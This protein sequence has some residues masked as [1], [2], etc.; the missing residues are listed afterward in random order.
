M[1]DVWANHIQRLKDGASQARTLEAV[2]EW[3]ERNTMMNGKPFSFSG[4]RYQLEILRDPSPN[5][6]VTKCSQIGASE[7]VARMVLAR[8]AIVQPYNV[9]Y[10]MPSAKASQ[11]FCK[12]RVSSVISESPYL[13]E[14]VDKN[15]D[16]VT[17]KKI[18]YSFIHFK[19][20][21]K[22]AQAISVNA[23]V[24]IADEYSYCD[25]TIVKQFNSR[26]TH[27]K[28]KHLIYFSTPTLPGIGIDAEF[29]ESKRKYR[30]CKCNHCNEWFWPNFLDHCVIPGYDVDWLSVTRS[31]LMKLPWRDTVLLCPNCGQSPDLS[32]ENR[33]WVCDNPD[34]GSVT[35]GYAISPF[36]VPS[37]IKPAYL[38][39]KSVAYNRK[40]DWLQQN[41]GVAAEDKES[42]ILR[43]ELEA[44]MVD[45]ADGFGGMVMGLDLGMIC[46]A[47]IGMVMP[48]GMM[49]IVHTE[50]IPVSNLVTRYFELKA[51]WRVR[52]TVADFFPYSETV[53]R[54]QERDMN[55]FA[56]IYVTTK[57]TEPFSVKHVE[58]DKEKGKHM[59]RRVNVN[60]DVAFDMMM[61][62]VRNKSLLKKRDANDDLWTKHMLSMKRLKVFGPNDEMMYQW[63]KTDGE[64]H[65][66]HSTV[67]A[68]TAGR[69][70]GMSVGS[71]GGMLPMLSSFKM[72]QK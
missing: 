9:I 57:S 32:H 29:A 45:G 54:M 14:M 37:I 24:V 70:L 51:Q 42:T 19:G 55:L 30:M 65:F 8:A 67:Y 39:E 63:Q 58:E 71:G 69:L 25:S 4:H 61:F 72:A 36:D 10:C 23:D 47:T 13:R 49:A 34:S 44:I 16:S 48:D 68:Q 38:A 62:A 59:V 40:I 31:Q 21:F 46:H 7:M 26:L 50:Q 1:N 33:Q 56:A 18:G 52:M 5:L 11:D 43:S 53:L 15:N 35:S 66:A 3:I 60:R 12:G 41:L 28:F 22:D 64:D 6:C 17:M 2:P 27:S 20:A